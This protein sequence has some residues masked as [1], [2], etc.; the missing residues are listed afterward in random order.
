MKKEISNSR[1]AGMRWGTIVSILIVGLMFG[2]YIIPH[3]TLQ[4]SDDGK[5]WHI[6]WEGSLAEAAENQTIGET[7]GGILEVFITNHN[8]A[9]NSTY[10]ENTSATIEGWCTTNMPGKTPF[11]G[12]NSV[13]IELD[14]TTTW[15]FLVRVRGNET[16]C[17]R[18]AIWHGPDLRVR[19][20]SADLS[21]SADTEMWRVESDNTSAKDF[22][23]CNFYH[24]NTGSGFSISK[25]QT[26]EVTSIK[27]E[28]YY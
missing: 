21:V 18:G 14:H 5:S 20:T 15:D 19:W 12:E 16:Q 28:A 22:L 4:L 17:K 26:A 2:T 25:D 7:A 6:I 23:W 24:N 1:K 8:A 27:L 11:T 10:T 3:P 9:A 13:G